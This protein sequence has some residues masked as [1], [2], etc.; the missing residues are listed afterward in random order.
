MGTLTINRA[1]LQYSR[2]VFDFGASDTLV[3]CTSQPHLKDT[4]DSNWLVFIIVN[5]CF[6]IICVQQIRTSAY[7]WTR[8][9]LAFFLFFFSQPSCTRYAYRHICTPAAYSDQ[10]NAELPLRSERLDHC[11]S[12]SWSAVK[13]RCERGALP[14]RRV[15]TEPLKSA[16]LRPRKHCCGSWLSFTGR[17]DTMLRPRPVSELPLP[18]PTIIIIHFENKQGLFFFFSQ[19]SLAQCDVLKHRTSIICCCP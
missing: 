1:A 18:D 14:V 6:S 11:F 9:T 13:P 8:W 3:F 16:L 12:L 15:Q 4:T 2:E 5:K 7:L 17:W 19:S 10:P